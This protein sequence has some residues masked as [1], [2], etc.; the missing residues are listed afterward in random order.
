[1][2]HDYCVKFEDILLRPLAAKDI[3]M[4]RLWRN[5]NDIRKCF[6][7]D[8]IISEE[9]QKT[10]FEKY[11]K[12]DNDLMFIIEEVTQLKSSI[13]TIAI[14]NINKH[15]ADAE[16]GR[17]I[18]GE[19][20]AS[21]KGLALKATKAICG[22]AFNTLGIDKIYLEVFDDNVKARKIYENA[23]FYYESERFHGEK[24]LLKMILYR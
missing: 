6:L 10:W 5:R 20:N 16:F 15:F 2:Q 21:G 22:F 7:F 11:L 19:K 4:I 3:E 12:Q 1:M 9:Q 13:G 18:I 8:N 17:L 24:K 14:Y 23:G